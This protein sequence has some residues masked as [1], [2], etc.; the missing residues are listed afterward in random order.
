MLPRQPKTVS[1]NLRLTP[2]VRAKLYEKASRYG[3]TSDVLREIVNAF[4]DGRLT[5][6]EESHSKFKELFN[7]NRK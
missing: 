2:D 6:E 3:Q 4:I 5:I 1:L 7:V